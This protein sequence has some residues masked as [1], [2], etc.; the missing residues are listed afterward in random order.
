[1][2][3]HEFDENT[4]GAKVPSVI[5]ACRSGTGFN[6]PARIPFLKGRSSAGS[7]ATNFEVDHGAV[8]GY[9]QVGREGDRADVASPCGGSVIGPA[10]AVL[11]AMRIE[12]A[13]EVA[14]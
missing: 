3:K 1:M 9:S 11:Y 7:A 12:T 2:R 6:I 5:R 4:L 8:D 10:P 14:L 13:R